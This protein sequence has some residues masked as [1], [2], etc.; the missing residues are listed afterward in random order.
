MGL[1]IL[2][3]ATGRLLVD[4][5]SGAEKCHPLRD[6][7][8]YSSTPTVG[9]FKTSVSFS[10]GTGTLI[11]PI[12]PCNLA[13]FVIIGGI[14]AG[15]ADG[16]V[17]AEPHTAIMGLSGFKNPFLSAA[18]TTNFASFMSIIGPRSRWKIPY[19]LR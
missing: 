9:A 2:R 5:Y 15:S 14:G 4:P 7:S 3:F 6:G 17:I 19:P 16:L 10:S 18:E 11:P 13:A 8:T 12:E 1:G